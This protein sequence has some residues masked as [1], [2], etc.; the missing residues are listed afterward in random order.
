MPR[1][2]TPYVFS[3]K[4][5][6]YGEMYFVIES[7]EQFCYN[8]CRTDWSDEMLIRIETESEIPIYTQLT[9][10]I[11]EGIAKGSLKS[12]DALPSVRAFAADLGVNMHTVNKSYHE[13]EKKGII[14]IV[15]KSGAVI[16]HYDSIDDSVMNRISDQLRP[17]IAEALV[18]GLDKEKLLELVSSLVSDIK[19]K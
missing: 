5:L 19:T 7:I 12:G 18:L 4:E 1:K 16:S 8:K 6:F 14:Q 9:N 17:Y 3:H 10:Q 15:P 13:L 2:H 11:I